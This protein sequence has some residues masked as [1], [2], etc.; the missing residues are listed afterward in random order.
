M[1]GIVYLESHQLYEH[2]GTIPHWRGIYDDHG[3]VMAAMT[4]NQDN[5]D[6]WE[7]AD[8]PQYEEKFTSQ[9]YKLGIDYIVYAMTH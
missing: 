3:R 1:P 4:F 9:G 7:H 5:G 6:S 8:N 2:G